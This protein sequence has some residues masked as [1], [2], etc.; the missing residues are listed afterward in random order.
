MD[1]D[2]MQTVDAVVLAVVGMGGAWALALWWAIGRRVRRLR[3]L[4]ARR[5]P[6]PVLARR[7]VAADRAAD[8]LARRVRRAGEVC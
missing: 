8:E 4:H 5:V 1:A 3:R 2:L 6:V 7:V